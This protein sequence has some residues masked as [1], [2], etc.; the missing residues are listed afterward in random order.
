MYRHDQFLTQ[1]DYNHQRYRPFHLCF[2]QALK[3]ANE[4]NRYE[5]RYVMT[6]NTSGNFKLT[7][8]PRLKAG[9]SAIINQSLKI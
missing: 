7:Y 6:Y 5:S 2:C 4:T 1:Y 9:V 3:D 8:S